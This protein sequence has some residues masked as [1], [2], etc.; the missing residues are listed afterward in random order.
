MLQLSCGL[1]SLVLTCVLSSRLYGWLLDCFKNA[2]I[3]TVMTCEAV[4]H[5]ESDGN[6]TRIG[7]VVKGMTTRLYEMP[8]GDKC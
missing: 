7:D 5:E 1:R 8:D 6:R 4:R 3:H 2:D